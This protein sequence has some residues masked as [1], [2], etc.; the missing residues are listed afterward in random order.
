M[1]ICVCVCADIRTDTRPKNT[2]RIRAQ[3]HYL[4]NKLGLK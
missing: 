1:C 4:T 2:Q 3:G